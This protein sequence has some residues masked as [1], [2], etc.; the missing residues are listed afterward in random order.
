MR[1]SEVDFDEGVVGLL[2]HLEEWLL[3]FDEGGLRLLRRCLDRMSPIE[4]KGEPMVLQVH[5][6]VGARSWTL[7]S[8]AH[9]ED[10]HLELLDHHSQIRYRERQPRSLVLSLG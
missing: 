10:R 4:M 6:R 8:V 5:L 9:L 1:W 7:P 3:R 2:L